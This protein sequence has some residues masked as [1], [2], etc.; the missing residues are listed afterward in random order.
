MSIFAFESTFAPNQVLP[1]NHIFEHFPSELISHLHSACYAECVKT[2]KLTCSFLYIGS[3]FKSCQDV[4]M[5]KILFHKQRPL[6]IPVFYLTLSERSAT[7]R[8]GVSCLRSQ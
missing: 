5:D 3:V 8:A 7:L 2:V 4:E 1:Q 6:E